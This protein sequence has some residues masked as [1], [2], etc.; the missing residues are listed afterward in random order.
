M[1]IG[2]EKELKVFE[3]TIHGFARACINLDIVIGS[4][5]KSSLYNVTKF[6]YIPGPLMI[7]KDL[8]GLSR[9]RFDFSFLVME[10]VYK[11]LDKKRD[12][13]F[14]LTQGWKKNWYYV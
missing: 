12:V 8:D 13:F 10:F 5:S 9:Y 11:V 3:A 6:S 14:S 1:S 4:K 2:K 7:H